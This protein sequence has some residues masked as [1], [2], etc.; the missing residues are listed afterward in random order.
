[1]HHTQ[2]CPEIDIDKLCWQRL[3][4]W[5]EAALAVKACPPE[6][7]IATKGAPKHAEKPPDQ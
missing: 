3:W 4:L 1:V 5:N 6:A 2:A 7:F